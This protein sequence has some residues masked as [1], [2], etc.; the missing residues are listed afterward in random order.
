[1]LFLVMG[2]AAG[3]TA[4]RTYKTFRGKNWQR[5]TLYTAVLFPAFLFTLFFIMDLFV[6]G[7]GSS[8]AIPFLDMFIVIVRVCRVSSRLPCRVA[9]YNA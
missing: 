9:S 8:Q 6:W 3:Y 1:M 4:A 5:T 2:I 7:D